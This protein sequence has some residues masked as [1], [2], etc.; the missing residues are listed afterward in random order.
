MKRIVERTQSAV[1]RVE[2]SRARQNM[3]VLGDA[4]EAQRECFDGILAEER[5]R[6][7][8]E[9]SALQR[10]I[11]ALRDEQARAQAAYKEEIER[12]TLA[13]LKSLGSLRRAYQKR[14]SGIR[15]VAGHEELAA[16]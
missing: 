8:V 6:A 12:I 5:L 13:H 16:S 4:L 15:S 10:D 2:L 7:Q 1:S 11:A 9:R 14:L 3:K